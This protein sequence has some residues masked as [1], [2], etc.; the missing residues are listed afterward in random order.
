MKVAFV[1]TALGAA[2]IVSSAC[3]NESAALRVAPVIPP[4][5]TTISFSKDLQPIFNQ[6]CMVNSGCHVGSSAPFGFVLEEGK[7][8]ANL[9][10]VPS[11][12]VPTLNRVEPGRSDLSYIINKLEGVGNLGDRMPA[13]GLYLSVAEIQLFKD[14]IDQGALDN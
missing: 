14:W 7:S 9:V 5:N 6:S 8:Y 11:A 2:A 4:D 12:E 13:T 3:T 1:L 10:G